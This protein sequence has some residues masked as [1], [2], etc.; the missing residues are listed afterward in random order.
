MELGNLEE[1]ERK[2]EKIRQGCAVRAAM[3]SRGR[4]GER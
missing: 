4:E 2:E 3:M 1:E